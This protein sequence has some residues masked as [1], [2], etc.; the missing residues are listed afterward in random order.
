MTFVK[1]ATKFENYS[2]ALTWL[3]KLTQINS[4]SRFYHYLKILKE[5]VDSSDLLNGGTS[6]N[7][8]DKIIEKYGENAVRG[9][10]LETDELIEIYNAFRNEP[11]IIPK[12]LLEEIVVGKLSEAEE[13]ANKPKSANPRNK[14]FELTVAARVQSSG[15]YS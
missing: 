3:A 7:Q 5:I 10:T 9:A 15:L 8:M 2:N 6:E 14:L 4:S 11:N 1:T 12:L 13:E